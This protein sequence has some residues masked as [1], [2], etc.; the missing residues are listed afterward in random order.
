MSHY[1]LSDLIDVSALQKLADANFWTAGIPFAI[2]DAIDSSILVAAGWQEICTNFHRDNPASCAR[3]KESDNYI[4][5]RL[6]EGEAFEYTCKNGLLDI[7]IPIIVAGEHLATLFMGQFFYEGETPDREF[8]VQQAHEYGYDLESYLAALDRVPVLS[9]STVNTILAYDKVLASFTADLAERAL[10]IIETREALRENQETLR[11]IVDGCPIPQFVIDCNHRVIYWNKAIENITGVSAEK[12]LGTKQSWNVF[13]GKARP[14]LADLL[15]DG[16]EA[17][18]PEHYP[19]NCIKSKVVPDAYEATDYFPAL[20]ENGRWLFFTAASLKDR[21]G[22]IIGAVETLEDISENKKAEEERLRVESRLQ[23]MQRLESLSILASGVA[24]DLNNAL[25]PII[26]YAQLTRMQLSHGSQLDTYLQS[27]E[28]AAES[29]ARLAG[30]MLAYS[31]KGR[32][33]VEAVSLSGLIN[34]LTATLERIVVKPSRLVTILEPDLPPIEADSAQLRQIVVALVTNAVEALEE[35]SGTITI[36]TGATVADRSFLDATIMGDELTEG[37]YAFLEV[38][39]TG[40][41]V[42]PDI[43]PKIFDP[44][45]STKFT[46]RG[47]SLAAV[48]GIVRGHRGSILV[49][50]C[51]GSGATFKVFFPGLAI[52]EPAVS[53]MDRSAVEVLQP[54][55]KILVVDDDP[56]VMQVSSLML[57]TMGFTVL[58]ASGGKNGIDLFREQSNDISAAFVDLTMQE[59]GGEEVVREL[60]K[61]NSNVMLVLMSGYTD[62]AISSELISEGIAGFIQKPFK[63]E[64]IRAKLRELKEN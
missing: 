23:E 7:G 57:E 62:Q 14:S 49:E 20:G 48:Q 58:T 60:R 32:F 25:Q 2:V 12:I 42:A 64:E 43:L 50:S 6:V 15:V 46:G 26:G 16:A 47:L 30:Q 34:S 41:G 9:R 10:R 4:K 5:A 24:H 18:I 45:F 51:P 63:V 31:G 27:I 1:R 8:F 33:K 29:A 54:N 17:A 36:R 21:K 56:A 22:A 61:I 38:S 44:F 13:Y 39:D 37:T 59:M 55:G 3:C 19:N 52:T 28:R 11:A 35:A 53:G 40:C